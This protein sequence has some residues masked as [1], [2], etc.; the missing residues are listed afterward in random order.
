[1]KSPKIPK[2]LQV[3]PHE[4]RVVKGPIEDAGEYSFQD[5]EIRI[6]SGL[7]PSAQYEVLM[8]EI[9]EAANHI[10]ELNLPHRTIQ[11]LGAAFAQAL[12]RAR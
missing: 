11:I 9:A 1:M 7:K 3:G 6:N 2:V 10:Y 8:H 4:L 12:L 5:L